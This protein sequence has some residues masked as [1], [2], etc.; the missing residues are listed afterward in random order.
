MPVTWQ[1]AI[2]VG[3]LLASLLWLAWFAGG[4]SSSAEPAW[5]LALLPVWALLLQP[6]V[7][8]VEVAL[9]GWVHGHD[10]APRPSARALVAAALRESWLAA[11]V[12]AWRQ[13]WRSGAWPDQ[14]DAP[15]VQGVVLVHGYLCNRA[16]WQNWHGWLLE[17]GVPHLSVS[18]A[19][20]WAD[21]DSYA[22]QL[23][24]A[25]ARL[26]QGTGR[27]PLL[28]G[29]SMGGLVIR[30]W[31]RWRQRRLAQAGDAGAAGLAR[32][33]MPHVVTLGTPHRGTWLA[34]WGG[35]LNVRQMAAG[36]AWLQQLLAGEE[37]GWRSRFTCVHS[38]CDNVVFPPAL[39]LLP[40]ARSV[41]LAGLAHLELAHDRR[42]CQLA[43][44]LLEPASGPDVPT[45]DAAGGPP[46]TG[47]STLP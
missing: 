38:H 16:L 26:V 37:P 19:P 30:A 44:D 24:Q 35:P 36:S 10:P 6:V 43:L 25:I 28:V 47:K 14:P 46:R 18:L 17:R 40:G 42:G 22:P 23:D 11:Q 4:L 27:T 41:H 39:A 15:G 29:H 8:L 3:A 7:F 34:R 1:R 33:D 20:A 13:P 12:F 31:W 9:V 5:W 2:S 45:L 32:I 21:I